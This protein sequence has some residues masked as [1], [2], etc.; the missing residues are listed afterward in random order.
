M[1]NKSVP[2]KVWSGSHTYF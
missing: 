1:D 2:K